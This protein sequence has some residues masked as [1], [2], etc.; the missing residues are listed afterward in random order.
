[1]DNVKYFNYLGCLKINDATCTHEIKSR[2]A[3]AEVAFNK[4]NVFI[5]KLDLNLRKKQKCYNWSIALN[6]AETWILRKVIRSTFKF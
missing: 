5:H 4:T 6:D 2:I 3:M 1:M